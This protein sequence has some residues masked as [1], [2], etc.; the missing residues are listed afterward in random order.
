[1]ARGGLAT[2]VPTKASVRSPMAFGQ[3]S[4]ETILMIFQ[5]RHTHVVTIRQIKT[6]G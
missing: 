5:F 2:R 1:M 4:E 6:Y 3:V